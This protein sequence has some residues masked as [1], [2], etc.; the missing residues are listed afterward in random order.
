MNKHMVLQHNKLGN[1]YIVGDIHGHYSNLLTLLDHIKFDNSIDRLFSVGDI[2]DRGPNSSNMIQLLDQPWFF[3]CMGNHEF[4]MIQSILHH[5][6]SYTNCWLNNG[7]DWSNYIPNNKLITLA[8]KLTNLPLIISII[9]DNN[10]TNNFNITHAELLN[11]N[12][13]NEIIPITNNDILNWNFN[14][15]NEDNILWGNTIILSHYYNKSYQSINTK[16]H[17]NLTLTYTGHSI[18]KTYQPIILQS[19]LYIDTG[20]SMQSKNFQFSS[21]FKLTIISPTSNTVHQLY[22]HNKQYLN[23][24]TSNIPIYQ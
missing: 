6:D 5:N 15:Q 21:Q 20:C 24:P 23:Y 8:N 14:K 19:H 13:Y 3:S 9:D 12:H 1:D 7:G 2:I 18:P 17:D 22:S 11:I 4:M 10:P 16:F